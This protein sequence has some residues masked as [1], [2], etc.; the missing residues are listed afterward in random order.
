M[1]INSKTT[2]LEIADLLEQDGYDRSLANQVR[3]AAS[4]G[5]LLWTR[6]R[7][8]TTD[9]SAIDARPSRILRGAR[10]HLPA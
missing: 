10:E 6:D 7:L 8:T 5:C 9:S 1:W 2:V 3:R 4:R